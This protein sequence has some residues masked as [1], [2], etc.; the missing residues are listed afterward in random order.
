MLY[1]THVTS[2]DTGYNQGKMYS[3]PKE[4]RRLNDE[5]LIKDSESI[6]HAKL[7]EADLMK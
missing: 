1:L 7:N 6:E 2:L 4:A 5:V 3:L